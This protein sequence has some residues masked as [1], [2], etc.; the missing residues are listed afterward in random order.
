MWNVNWYLTD[1]QMQVIDGAFMVTELN[2]EMEEIDIELQEPFAIEI[3][4]SFAVDL[5]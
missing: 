2:I 3:D 4:E 5:D 1:E